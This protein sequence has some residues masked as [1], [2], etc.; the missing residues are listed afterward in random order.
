MRIE[1]YPPQEPFSEAGDK[2]AAE[3]MRLG[4]GTSGK[5]HSYGDDPYQS[6]S[7]HVPDKPNGTVLAFVHGGGWTS[8]YKEHMNFM[9]PPMLAAGIIFISIGYRLA[10]QHL[11]PTG[12]EDI[13]SALAS[14]YQ[15]IGKFGGDP[16]RIYV[17]GHSAGGHYTSLLAVRNDWQAELN[18]PNT[19]IRGCLPISGVYDFAAKSG[20]TMRPRFLVD[21]DTEVAASPIHNMHQMRPFLISHGSEDF[22]HLMTQAEKMESA[23]DQAGADVSRI[24]FDGRNHFSASYAGGEADGPWVTPAIKW[25][26]AH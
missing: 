11:F 12:A 18:L 17:G 2:Y 1:D 23:L 25:M 26:E 6:L 7:L 16:E 22:P 14:I 4:D 9:A 5:D 19:V 10:P 8:G 13:A 24:V 3:V 21:V 20:L 15:R